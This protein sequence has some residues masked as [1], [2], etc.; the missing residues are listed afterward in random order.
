MKK[1][2]RTSTVTVTDPDNEDFVSCSKENK[3]SSIAVI[4]SQ[5]SNNYR[6]HKAEKRKTNKGY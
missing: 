2:L 4:L 5:C 6:Y 1:K 3:G